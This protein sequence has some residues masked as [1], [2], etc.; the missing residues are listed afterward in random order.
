MISTLHWRTFA[1]A[2]KGLQAHYS[3]LEA[4]GG[5]T[6]R[7]VVPPSNVISYEFVFTTLYVARSSYQP[8]CHSLLHH[9]VLTECLDCTH[10]LLDCASDQTLGANFLQRL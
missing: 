6:V 3:G 7:S 10:A 8:M 2:K 5:M 9:A 4:T 1:V